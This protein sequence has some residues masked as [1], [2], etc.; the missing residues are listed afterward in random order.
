MR[1]FLYIFEISKNSI[2][3]EK[4]KKNNIEIT[5]EGD[6]RAGAPGQED[7]VPTEE[8]QNPIS[9]EPISRSSSFMW[10][11]SV[12]KADEKMF[13][14]FDWSVY[15]AEMKELVSK[16]M[17]AKKSSSFQSSL[18]SVLQKVLDGDIDEFIEGAIFGAKN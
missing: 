15:P 2:L 1:I 7:L 6:S 18:E 13:D 10:Q 11:Q 12:T 9:G 5:H 14:A 16:E 8:L 3:R 4:I 17:K